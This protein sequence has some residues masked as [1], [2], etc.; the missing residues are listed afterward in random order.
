MKAERVDITPVGIDRRDALTLEKPRFAIMMPLNVVRPPLGTL[1]AI[2][3]MSASIH[4]HDKI[5]RALT[6]KKKMI[7]VFGSMKAS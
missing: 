4:L 3:T 2:W 1:I 5:E 7:Q 6:L